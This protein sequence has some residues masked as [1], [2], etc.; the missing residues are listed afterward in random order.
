MQYNPKLKKAAKEI[1]DV[2]KKYDIAGLIL[3][4]S[5]GHGEFLFNLSPTYSALKFEG[6]KG[7][8]LKAKSEDF[9]NGAI[10]RD[11]A[12]A[13]TSNMLQILYD[14]GSTHVNALYEMSSFVNKVTNAEH[15]KGKTSS[16]EEQNN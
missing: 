9:K 10:G 15:T 8:R 4:H 11:K 12:L 16:H 1:E 14:M 2:L 13:D 7:V 3:L 6:V 5:P